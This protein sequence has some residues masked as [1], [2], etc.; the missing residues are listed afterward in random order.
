MTSS[1]QY[2]VCNVNT[3]DTPL[4]ATGQFR[5][6]ARAH[7]ELPQGRA[8]RGAHVEALRVTEEPLLAG[9]VC[10]SS[11]LLGFLDEMEGAKGGRRFNACTSVG[12]LQYISLDSRVLAYSFVCTLF[13]R[14][15][16]RRTLEPSATPPGTQDK[17][18]GAVGRSLPQRSVLRG[19]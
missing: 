5:P 14:M 15:A 10:F 3:S 18:R 1:N 13:S 6:S 4:P 17:V 9:S 8:V 11:E 7:G 16:T 2:S 12:N 19:R